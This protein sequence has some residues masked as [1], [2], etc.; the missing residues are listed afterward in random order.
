MM[1]GPRLRDRTH[2]YKNTNS[3]RKVFGACEVDGCDGTHRLAPQK[4]I[5]SRQFSSRFAARR[6]CHQHPASFVL[7]ERSPTEKR[8]YKQG[9]RSYI[10]L[11]RERGVSF[12]KSQIDPDRSLSTAER[13]K[14][15][16]LSNVGIRIISTSSSLPGVRNCIETG[17]CCSRGT[18]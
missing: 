11:K 2:S 12:W 7:R 10:F 5:Y 18:D 17:S 6:P 14:S 13:K 9:A 3:L 15:D 1:N 8:T 4:Y 16:G